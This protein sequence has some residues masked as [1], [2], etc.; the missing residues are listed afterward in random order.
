MKRTSTIRRNTAEKK[1][2]LE[3]LRKIPIVQ[4]ACERADIGRTTYYRWRR[5]D[6]KF[7]K[8]A[9]EAM[10]DGEEMINDLSESQLITLIKEKNFSAIQL[11]LRQHHPKYRTKVELTAKIEDES[12]TPEEE[13]LVRKAL[14][15]DD[16]A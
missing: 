5:E 2:L 11:W 4:I 6:E 8:L 9:D 1:V 13:N 3:Q 12:L 16:H 7:K 10:Q 14:G 15:I